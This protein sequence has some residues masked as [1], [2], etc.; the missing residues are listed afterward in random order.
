MNR[1][2]L[3]DGAANGNGADLA[4]IVNGQGHILTYDK[5]GNRTSDTKWG[6]QVVRQVSVTSR[7]DAGNPVASQVSYVNHAGRVTEFYTYDRM[8]RL[9]TVSAG[10]YD[11]GWNQLP[12][13][14]GHCAGHPP[15]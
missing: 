11:E 4:N 6:Q 14:Q 1:Q 2:I 9:S 3:V 10:A 15:V 12:A 8:N 13:G 5:N 7:D